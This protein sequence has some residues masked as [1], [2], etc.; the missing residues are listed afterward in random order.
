MSR[1]ARSACLSA[2]VAVCMGSFVLA[3]DSRPADGAWEHVPVPERHTDHRP[4]FKAPF[5]DGPS[6]TR[7][8]LECH[9]DDAREVMQTA[10]W[11]LL[12]EEV[13]VPGHDTPT[14]I[15]KRNLINNFCI[16]ISSNWPGC[17]SCHIGYG[18]EDDTFDFSDPTRVDCLVCH[19][20]SGQYQKKYQGAGHP[21]PGVDLLAAAKSVGRPTR[22]NCG[23]CHFMG[24]GAN[25]VKHG[26]LD[27]TLLFPSGGI[28]VHMG[29][30]GFECV[31]CH[32][33]D[34]HRIRGRGSTVSVDTENRLRCT[35]CHD[36]KPHA[37]TRVNQHTERVSCQACHIPHTAVKEPTKMS[38]D[39]SAA[40]QDLGITDE[41]VYLKIK[42]RFTYAL[43]IKPEY[44]WY[45][46][47][48]GRYLLGDRIDP[49][50]VTPINQ[51]LGDRMDPSAKIHPFKV[52]RGRQIYDMENKYFILPHVH[53]PEGFWTRF[54]WPT[55]ARIGSQVARLPYSG[56][57]DFAPTEMFLHQNHMVM[58][59]EKALQC[60]D[61]HGRTGRLDWLALGYEGD[62]I[63]RTAEE[64]IPFP[65]M[66]ADYE[67]VFETGKPLSAVVTCGLCHELD[68][69][70]FA[71]TH[72]YHAGIDLDALP[73]E[74]RR[75]MIDGPRLDP[76]GENDMNCFLCHL[77]AADPGARDDAL[78]SGAREW[79]V[80]ATL[81]ATG[82]LTHTGGGYAWQPD[83][84]EDGEVTLDLGP[85][86]ESGC[87]ICHGAVH[88]GTTPLLV[89]LGNGSEWTS[90][91]TGQVFSPQRMRLSGMNLADKDG[92]GRSWDV[93][94]ERLV[95]CGDCHY[96]AGRPERLAGIIPPGHR[97]EPGEQRRR[98][99]SCHSL[100]MT[101][102]WLP[103]RKR[104]FAAVACESCHV[105]RLH[106]GAQQ[107][108]DH[109]VVQQDGAPRRVYRGVAG[110][111]I[112]D[113]VSAYMTGY[114][115]LL[116][117]GRTGD[118]G[119]RVIPW[120]LVAE[121]YWVDETTGERVPDEMV[122]EAWLDDDGYRPALVAVLD[123]D[124]D[125]LL[126]VEEL[127]LDTDESVAMVAGRLRD[128]GVRQP[129]IRGELRSYHIHH[130]VTHG[131]LVNQDCRR[132]HAPDGRPVERRF[133][134]A[135][136]TPGS[137]IPYPVGSDA[138]RLDGQLVRDEAGRLFLESDRDVATGFRQRVSGE[139]AK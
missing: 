75:L 132:C 2:L 137:V 40:G 54:D 133:E 128:L 3:D 80:S 10:H 134:I 119:D 120:N 86:P 124:G 116:L 138:V 48:S 74:R 84:A 78:S 62:P 35:D 51:P 4:F 18:F 77:A 12:G 29:E 32:Q 64:H 20:N 88:D 30:L 98:C 71:T 47:T 127:Q 59:A 96:A 105:P 126:S 100:D 103:D 26:D 122:R 45:N 36:P 131:D 95:E 93:H 108:V 41:H 118:G 102:E 31:D 67:P 38:W 115:P 46:E 110:G 113:A 129:V 76:E 111:R 52:H 37:D 34:R 94:S 121:W 60:R 83:A 70:A 130:N 91:K 44:Y 63:G 25:A 68:T 43:G 1:K 56:R 33:A 117:T 28:D 65:L 135:S 14:R 8:C 97:P 81:A 53:G 114:E 73:P 6:V 109:T 112:D 66:D 24:G 72:A 123:R 136:Y 55:A 87:G 58:P 50:E 22:A 23:G 19:D 5:E 85:A 61:C 125:G 39:W 104:H 21:D 27:N 49:A 57:F 42:G 15:G 13:L 7:A 11:N 82:L 90:E 101:H 69:D 106:L 17:T 99:E 89:N 16:G 139:E 107:Q 9:A 79:S 92:L